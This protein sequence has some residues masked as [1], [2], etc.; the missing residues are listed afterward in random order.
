M[1]INRKSSI[2]NFPNQFHF[3]NRKSSV[4]PQKSTQISTEISSFR[5]H[6]Y[7]EQTCRGE[8]GLKKER[9]RGEGGW[10]EREGGAGSEDG[11]VEKRRADQRDGG[12]GGLTNGEEDEEEGDEA[13][14][15]KFSFSVFTLVV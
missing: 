9:S 13:A 6:I 7:I 1:K 10:K 15:D 11:E 2:I 12:E 5:T 4:I 3:I 8:E 14:W